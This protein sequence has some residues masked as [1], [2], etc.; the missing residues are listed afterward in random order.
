MDGEKYLRDITERQNLLRATMDRKLWRVMIAHV[1]RGHIKKLVVSGWL[2]EPFSFSY[3]CNAFLFDFDVLLS[4]FLILIYV[5]F[6]LLQFLVGKVERKWSAFYF[7][8]FVAFFVTKLIL[9]RIYFLTLMANIS[10]VALIL[11]FY[12]S[13]LY[14]S[15]V[16]A[17][18]S[19]ER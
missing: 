8:V 9:R 10:F 5:F 16:Y 17:I 11:L 6:F 18:M 7:A 3:F 19:Q 4:W 13:R 14:F 1:L 12:C 2:D 15:S